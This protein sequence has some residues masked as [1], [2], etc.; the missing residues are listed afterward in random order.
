MAGGVV[1]DDTRRYAY[2]S[3]FFVLGLTSDTVQ[4]IP[5]AA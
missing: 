3:G 1:D 4:L 5:P 2:E